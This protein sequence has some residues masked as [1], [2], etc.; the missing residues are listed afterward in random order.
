MHSLSFS[1]LKKVHRTFF[2]GATVFKEIICFILSNCKTSKGIRSLRIPFFI[3]NYLVST[4]GKQMH[5]LCFSRLKKVHRTFFNGATVFKEIIC[6]ILSNC[7]TLK[8]IHSS[9]MPF[10]IANY[11]VSTRGKQMHSLNPACPRNRNHKK[12]A[13]FDFVKSCATA[14]HFY[15]YIIFWVLK[16]HLHLCKAIL[17]SSYREGCFRQ[18]Y[19]SS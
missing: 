6:F 13:A 14:F 10:F 17:L 19:P 8:G 5:S 4:R 12:A 2:N 9:W 18:E 11:L 15:L 7:K 1:H 16:P 3:A